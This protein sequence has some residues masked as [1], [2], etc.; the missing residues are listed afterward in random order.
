MIQGSPRLSVIA[1]GYKHR[2]GDCRR[3]HGRVW[4][5]L[6]AKERF[7]D[8]QVILLEAREL[9]WAASG[10][11]GGFCEASLTHGEKNGL[12]RWPEE[13]DTLSHGHREP[14]RDG[15]H[16]EKYAR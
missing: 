10:R 4:S 7:P 5:A 1:G 11:N 2:S 13:Y 8:Q 16:V 14:G 6:L 9:V 15:R 3:R 12:R